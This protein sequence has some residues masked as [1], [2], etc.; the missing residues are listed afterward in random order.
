MAIRI[1]SSNIAICWPCSCTADILASSHSRKVPLQNKTSYSAAMNWSAAVFYYTAIGYSLYSLCQKSAYTTTG[2]LTIYSVSLLW[3][4]FPVTTILAIILSFR[5]W[6]CV[7]TRYDCSSSPPLLYLHH[8]TSGIAYDIWVLEHSQPVARS[9]SS[10]RRC[11]RSPPRFFKYQR[12]ISTFPYIGANVELLLSWALIRI[13]SL[14]HSIQ[15]CEIT[16]FKRPTY[17]ITQ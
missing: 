10:P 2:I 5:C 4:L 11:C 17:V 12:R 1:I 16:H 8:R 15:G 14:S 7:Q 9:S 6:P 3:L 13:I